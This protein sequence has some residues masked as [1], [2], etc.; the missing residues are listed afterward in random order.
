MPNTCTSFFP[1]PADAIF[2][3]TFPTKVCTPTIPSMA[4]L[5]SISFCFKTQCHVWDHWRSV[6]IIQ[7]VR[8]Q[9][10]TSWFSRWAFWQ[11]PGKKGFRKLTKR[12]YTHKEGEWVSDMNHLPREHGRE[13]PQGT[14]WKR[15]PATYPRG[16]KQQKLTFG[17]WL[18]GKLTAIAAL[19]RNSKHI[20]IVMCCVCTT[21]LWL[22]K[23]SCLL[24]R[25]DKSSRFCAWS[26][27]FIR[28][29]K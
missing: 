24:R 16:L 9:M 4:Y 7:S 27:M 22:P 28:C 2:R 1:F 6:V 14:D 12:L 26:S 18:N 10:F 20:T 25:N 19:Y 11:I 15:T 29:M 5:G 3:D 8:S 13:L 23:D 17:Y 21:P